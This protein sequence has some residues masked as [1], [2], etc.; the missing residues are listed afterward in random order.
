MSR[1]AC[2]WIVYE[3]MP[4]YKAASREVAVEVYE[5]T[6]SE[7]KK[8]WLRGPIEAS[9]LGCDCSVRFGLEQSSSG[10]TKVRPIDDLS[11]SMVNQTTSRAESVQPHGV[12]LLAAALAFRLTAKPLL[13][14]TDLKKAYKQLGVSADALKDNFFAVDNQYTGKKEIYGCTVLPFG[15]CAAVAAFCRTSM[16]VW[17][18]G[19]TIL[20]F[21]WAVFYDDF[22]SVTELESAQHGEMCFDGLLHC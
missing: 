9:E 11:E 7:V 5:V 15:A 10:R 21:Y 3:G 1:L 4:A 16:A 20:L 6:Q 22:F 19:C 14:T 2:L 17:Y 8:G 18:L 12:D 13:K